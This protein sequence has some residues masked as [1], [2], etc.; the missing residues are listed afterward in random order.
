MKLDAKAALRSDGECKSRGSDFPIHNTQRTWRKPR[1]NY[2]TFVVDRQS[3]TPELLS[4]M[5]R[6]TPVLRFQEA[7][8]IALLRSGCIACMHF[9]AVKK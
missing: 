1:S 6:A 4:G 2:L 8:D 9:Q 7:R 3:Y 5:D